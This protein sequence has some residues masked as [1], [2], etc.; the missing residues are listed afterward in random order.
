[1]PRRAAP[2]TYTDSVSP[3]RRLAQYLSPYWIRYTAGAACLFAATGFALG[4]PWMVKSAV[5][6]LGREGGAAVPRY[7][8]AI[9]LLA[10]GR[11]APELAIPDARSRAVGGARRAPG[12]LPPSAAAA[13]ALLSPA[14]DRRSD[15]ARLERHL[16]DP[17]G[18]RIRHRHADGHLVHVHRHGERDVADRSLAHDLRDGAVSPPRPDRQALPSRRRGALDRGAGAARAPVGAAA[19]ESRGD[20]SGSRLHDGGP[21]DRRLRPAEPRVPGEEPPA[22]AGA[23]RVV[24]VDGIRVRSRRAHHPLA[25]RPGGRGS[26][27]TARA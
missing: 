15:V 20:A 2:M 18:R 21:G 9:L 1:R 3:A 6:A 12:P 16:G 14:P 7:V 10:A 26:A 8:G 4:I 5:D 17:I 22:R 13:A 11:G 25:G 24:A 27:D 23:G 19:G